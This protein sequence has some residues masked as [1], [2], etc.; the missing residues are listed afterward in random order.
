MLQFME[1]IVDVI[2]APYVLCHFAFLFWII[3]LFWILK[4]KLN[5]IHIYDISI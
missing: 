3:Q 4:N 1:E 5:Y 2:I